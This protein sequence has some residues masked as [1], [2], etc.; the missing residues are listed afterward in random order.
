MPDTDNAAVIASF[1]DA[2]GRRDAEA[3]VAC[4]HPEVRFSDP[5]FLDLR[6]PHA[7]NMWRMLCERAADLEIEASDISADESSGRAHWE[8]RYTFSATGRPVHNR[9]EARFRFEDGQII[10]H[11]DAFP[12]WR[13]T[14]MALGPAGTLL[15]WSPLVQN[16]V[17]AQAAAGLAVFERDRAG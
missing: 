3:M 17:R 9:I 1:Y 13:W 2:F 4:Y 14:R 10:E 11:R 7:G 5:V 6:G 16:K 15:G 8:A 12:L